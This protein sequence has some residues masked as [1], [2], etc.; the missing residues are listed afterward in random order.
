LYDELHQLYHHFWQAHLAEP[1]N[2]VGG[3][4][5]IGHAV[6]ANLVHWAHLPVAVWN[7]QAYDSVAIYT[8]SA[9]IVN[10]IPTMV[11]PGLCSASQWP[12]CT[13]G[14]NFAIAIPSD[15]VN[16][17]LLTNWSKPAY[18]P[19]VQNV[20]RD[21]STAWQTASGEW[22]FTDFE[23]KIYYSPDFV[24]WNVASNG[25]ALFDTAECPD[26]FTL[27]AFCTDPGCTTPPPGT[28]LPT[29]VHKQS[30]G[31]QDWYTLGIYGDGTSGSTGTWLPIRADLQALDASALLNQH[32]FYASKSFYDPVGTRR[33]Y[34]GWALVPPASTQ[35]LPRVTTYHAGLQR[36]LFNPLPEL[37][38]LRDFPLY[39]QTNVPIANGSQILLGAWEN[40][41]GNQSETRLNFDLPSTSAVFGVNIGTTANGTG[42]TSI[43]ISY[44]P[45]S[46]TANVTV[47]AGAQPLSY[48]MPGIDLP[49]DDYNVTNVNYTD[50]HICQASCT[51]DANCMAYTYVV[52]PP[53]YASCCLK[54]GVPAPNPLN[55]CTSGAKK[56]PAF[57]NGV[58]LPILPS[59]TNIDVVVYMDNTFAEV[60]VLGGR[61]AFTVNVPSPFDNGW[62]VS[63]FSNSGSVN[64]KNVN[65]WHMG[66]IW[67]APFEVLAQ[68][69]I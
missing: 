37:T 33:I 41:A 40:S 50:P 46:R 20:Q 38:S 34:W 6:S 5:V 8:G 10:G 25:T 39:S 29:H 55:T 60:F 17:P 28:Q 61:L 49:G 21:P 65:V 24:S 62:G 42:G 9:T 1:Q 64:A 15:H 51:A 67:I 68:R 22:R 53:L 52:R 47:G 13:T 48:Y 31:G 54:N 36:L 57:Q 69:N 7:D 4:P 63:L 3:G 16:D 43:L 56:S 18:N 30:S 26:F 66:S 45:V 23:G 11:Y 27:P 35:S 12:N 44:D 19:V 32:T 58:P 2:G 59:D 14:T